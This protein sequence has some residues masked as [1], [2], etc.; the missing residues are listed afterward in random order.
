MDGKPASLAYDC[1][2]LVAGKP[3][4]NNSSLL[5]LVGELGEQCGL[6]WAGRWKKFKERVHFEVGL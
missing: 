3:A 2:P 4:W 1:V 6:I 5:T